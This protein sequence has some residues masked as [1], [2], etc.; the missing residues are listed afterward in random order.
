[1]KTLVMGAGAIGSVFGGFLSNSQDV[2]LIGRVSYISAIRKKGLRVSGIWGE[3]LFKN[4]KAFTSA[5][6]CREIS[7]YD[8]IL[9]TTKSYDTEYATM[10]ILPLIGNNSIVVSVQNGIGN[11]E[12]I[13]KIVGKERT[14]GGMAIFG[15]MMMEPGHVKVTVYAS[16]CLFGTIS[17]GIKRAKTVAEI[18]AKSGIPS[19]PTD[20]IIREKWMK[21]F[22]NIAL[23]PLSA[24]LKVRYGVLGKY[25]ETRSIMRGM[26]QEAFEVAEAEKIGLKFTC[27]DYFERLIER[28]LPPTADHIS[29]ML[30]DLERGKRTEVDFIN[31]AI[32]RMGKRHNIETPVNETIVNIIKA[33]G[34]MHGASAP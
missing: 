28:Q 18:I 14:M 21:V 22:Y 24:I 16:E 23:N 5:D 19:L 20:D 11:E 15:A 3:H 8:L 6:E 10:Q 25:D 27:E 29:S 13:A 12:T 32:V 30:Q 17:G 9:M 4:L 31:G 1:M 7:P 33:L 2:T 34:K 26:L